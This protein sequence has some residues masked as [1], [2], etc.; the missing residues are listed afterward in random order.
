[1]SL[2]SVILLC[3][4]VLIL[5]RIVFVI[6]NKEYYISHIYTPTY[7]ERNPASLFISNI[8]KEDFKTNIE[9]Q[10]MILLGKY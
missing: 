4:F 8:E 10:W 7:F 3:F 6:R 5:I 1:M 2:V 9:I